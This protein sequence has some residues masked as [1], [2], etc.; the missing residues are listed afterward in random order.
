MTGILIRIRYGVVRPKVRI[1]KTSLVCLLRDGCGGHCRSIRHQIPITFVACDA[2]VIYGCDS[3]L[4]NLASA[5]YIISRVCGTA[6]CRVGEIAV[7]GDG[8]F[9]C[10]PVSP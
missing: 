7:I 6:P 10:I 2:R 1:R 3:G 9:P 4:K 5:Q 8:G